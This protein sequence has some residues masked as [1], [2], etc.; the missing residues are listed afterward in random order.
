MYWNPPISEEDQMIRSEL[1][2]ILKQKPEE[3]E[4]AVNIG[5]VQSVDQTSVG[6]C[7]DWQLAGSE[8][9]SFCLQFQLYFTR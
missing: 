6:P 8:R 1:N 3:S 9:T 5:Q 2:I 7:S 4:A